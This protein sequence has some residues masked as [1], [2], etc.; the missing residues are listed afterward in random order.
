MKYLL[1]G[2]TG[3]LGQKLIE[4]LLPDHDV[5]V[6]SRDE[7]KH[8]TIRNTYGVGSLAA[9]AQTS[10]TFFVGDVRDGQRIRDVLRQYRPTTI[11]VAS[12]LKQVETCELSPYESIQTNLLGVHNAIEAVNAESPPNST[13]LLVSTDKCV[14][15]VNVY[16]M[17]KA[18]AER[19]VTSQARTGR[20]DIK[21]LAVRYGN[22]LESRGS[23][24][25][26]FRY[27]AEHAPFLTVTC[28]DMTRFIMTLG[29]SVALIQ[30]ALASGQSGETWIPHLPAMRIGDL[31][32]I[33]SARSG[34]PIKIVGFRPGEKMHEELINESESP[35]MR[36]S[37]AHY[38]LGPAYVPGT[39][40]RFRYT[41]ETTVLSAAAIE[42]LLGRLIDLPV[43]NFPGLRIE[44]IA[45]NRRD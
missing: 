41:S 3:S 28:P 23:I 15:P 42:D 44:E 16:G 40:A 13:V 17:S 37:G 45:T 24:V 1:I 31:A 22:V 34:K 5:A 19:V 14:S 21:Y 7:A 33:F 2:G 32:A 26:L 39:G 30:Q 27:Q 11:I 29:E 38:V 4:S 10:L 9:R 8:W 43:A 6:Y 25:P 20:S 12:A 35:R 18:I 36:R